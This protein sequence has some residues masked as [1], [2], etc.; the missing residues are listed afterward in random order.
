MLRTARM[1]TSLLSSL[2]VLLC[3]TAG[4]WAAERP[5]APAPEEGSRYL[6]MEA[7]IALALQNN[8]DLLLAQEQIEESRGVAKGRLGG[9]LPN[10]SGTTDYH[11]LKVFQGVFG[12]GPVAST[13]RNIW[14]SRA[15]MTQPL[16]SLSLIQQWLAG[17]VGVEV[18]DLEAEVARRDTIAT[19]ALFYL[20]ALRAE[21]AV[22]AHESNVELSRRLLQL[23]EG[24]KKAGAATGIDV[25][26]AKTQVKNERQLLFNARNERNRAS[27]NLVRA[28]GIPDETRIVL[29]DKLQ[30]RRIE[31]QDVNKA[32]AMAL[33]RRAEIE[34]QARRLRFAELT[35][36]STVS[37]RIP[38]LDLRGDYGLIGE[39]ADDRV[40][41]YSA[42]AYIT[43][44]LYDGRR[45]GRISET[46][47]QL[48][49]AE[50]QTKNLVL[51][52]SIEARDAH[53]AIRLTRQQ[54]VVAEEALALAEE[55]LR[56][57][58]RAFSIGTL[59]H[60][61][62]ITAQIGVAT[63]RDSAIEALFN[64]NAARVNLA[65]ALGQMHRIYSGGAVSV[66]RWN[67]PAG[68]RVVVR[69]AAPRRR[70]GTAA[71]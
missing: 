58:Q 63:A 5:E 2:V 59:T 28:M 14:D 38:S 35:L 51:R 23:T 65:R 17:R 3:L 6:S 49:Q 48:R 39:E 13:P 45:E 24:R 9:L 53:Q 42:G 22:K 60:L 19:A 67:Q 4:A 34:A 44:P 50:I 71:R 31:E 8:Y 54:A 69:T 16:F 52:V 37:E 55:Q 40:S 57:S 41:T 64:F 29:T 30:L 25:I 27:L 11:R 18:A 21:T 70:P 1:I 32:V 7:A 43:W 62:V 26:R 47:S 61:E 20:E 15:R 46:R 10:V 56:L 33:T 36:D 66:E 12:G 68:D